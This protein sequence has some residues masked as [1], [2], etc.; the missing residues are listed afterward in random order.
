MIEKSTYILFL[1]LLISQ[2]S[3]SKDYRVANITE[4]NESVQLLEPGDQIILKNG[5]WQD[6]DLRFKARGSK[7]KPITL[8]AETRGKVIISGNSSLSMAGRYL[9]VRD[10]WF[11]DGVA[12]GKA[13]IS[14]RINS[15][16]FATHSRLTNCAIT[17]FNPPRD[18]IKYSFVDLWGKSNRIDHNYLSGKT[19]EGPTV[20][21]WLKGEEHQNNAHCI[22]NNY[23][24]ERPALGRNGGETIR[25]GTSDNSMYDS[26]T[27]IERNYFEKCN[28]ESEVISNKSGGNEF[29]DNLFY[30]SQGSLVLRHGDNAIVEN[31]V[32]DGNN[33]KWT[34]GVR[35]IN[36][37][38]IIRNNLFLN[39]RGEDLKSPF[40]IMNGVPNS[41]LNRYKQVKRVDV[42]FNTFINC[43]S[44]R[45]GAGKDQEKSL[46][47]EEIIFANNLF[48]PT[49]NQPLFQAYDDLKGITFKNNKV[50]TEGEIE[51]HG[52]ES[53]AVETKPVGNIPIPLNS[54]R[55]LDA[56]IIGQYTP[57]ID[58]T[59]MPR[60]NLFVG[61]FHPGTD[62]MPMALQLKPGPD[63]IKPGNIN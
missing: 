58:I 10:I 15:R 50:V 27:K 17:N 11:K 20:I 25:I 44:L 18:T 47:P 55:V 34:G 19:N 39:L 4:F 28:G 30:E 33:V 23:F 52:F 31:N 14:F 61:A 3:F 8:M 45:F 12:R 2:N 13:V 7:N 21:V 49:L 32:F 60:K 59:S 54:N 62:S 53:I 22:D 51:F 42:Q 35:V 48:F 5:V 43:S 36:Q 9:I 40:V 46:P 37:G 26:F 16:D 24:G 57:E 41:P 63:W 38:H 29:R 56:E 6:V 1:L